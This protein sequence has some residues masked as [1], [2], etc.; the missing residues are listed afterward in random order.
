MF[1]I[2]LSFQDSVRSFLYGLTT[3]DDS[4]GKCEPSLSPLIPSRY[5]DNTE[6][7]LIERK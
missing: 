5:E 7:F 1:D 2:C 3:P 4:A 6:L